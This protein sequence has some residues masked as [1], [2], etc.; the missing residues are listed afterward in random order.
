MQPSDDPTAAP[1]ITQ[2][3]VLLCVRGLKPSARYLASAFAIDMTIS[4]AAVGGVPVVVQSDK[5]GVLQLPHSY[6]CITP[7]VLHIKLEL[8]ALSAGDTA[9][10]TVMKSD[11]DASSVTTFSLT[12]LWL[13][14]LVL[15]PNV[16]GVI[17][18]S[19][20][21]KAGGEPPPPLPTL[22]T[23]RGQNYRGDVPDGGWPVVAALS[24]TS[25]GTVAILTISHRDSG[26]YEYRC[27]QN[28]Q[29]I[30]RC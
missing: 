29:T 3:E 30:G 18:L 17:H 20:A 11:D 12:P 5:A 9:G 13:P 10:A 8:E 14:E 16:S 23:F 7:R 6:G 26:Y 24:N 19:P 2:Q 28:N 25:N 21:F 1:P 4:N 27:E 22:L 15:E